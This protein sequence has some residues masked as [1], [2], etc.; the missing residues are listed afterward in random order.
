[1]EERGIMKG[2]HKM[3]GGGKSSV[4]EIMEES[5]MVEV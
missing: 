2:E 5:G 4:R 3:N 1:M